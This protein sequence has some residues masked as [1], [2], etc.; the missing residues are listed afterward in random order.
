VEWAELF[1]RVDDKWLRVQC[2]RF[3]RRCSARGIIPTQVTQETV[4]EFAAELEER[5]APKKARKIVV[6]T[7]RNWKYATMQYPK[8]WPLVRLDPGSRQRFYRTPW[9]EVDANFRADGERMLDAFSNPLNLAKGLKKPYGARSIEELRGILARLYTVALTHHQPRQAITSLADLVRPDVAHSILRFY[10]DRFGAEN[11][12]QA[13]TVAD[14]LCVVA[15]Y[16]VRAPEDELEILARHRSVLKRPP[17]GMTAKNR[18]MLRR[19]IDEGRV[20]RLLSQGEQ[21]LA[22]FNKIRSPLRRDALALEVALAIEILIAAP[23]RPK[24]LASISL[25]RHLVSTGE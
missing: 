15:K 12:E 18:A 21:A 14:V 7:C 24:N 16:W 4:D 6:T 11:T 1:A 10:L 20:D 5:L 3:A 22:A 25:S 23:V 13:G 8:V 9:A 19:F 2:W 17:K